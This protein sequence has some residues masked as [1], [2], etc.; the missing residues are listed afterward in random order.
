MKV[1]ILGAH[2][3]ESTNTKLVSLLVDDV[4]ALDAGSL[5]SSLSLE[6]QQRIKAILLTHHHFDHIRDIATFGLNARSWG[7]VQ[8]CG[9]KVTLDA[10]SRYILNGEIYPNLTEK[11][12]EREPSIEF[13]QLE[14]YEVVTIYQYQILPLPV[15]HAIP[16][17][18]YQITS[19][20]GKSLFYSGDTGPGCSSCWEHIAP[21]VIII[22]VTVPN[23]YESE[24]H[25]SG[26]LS[27]HLL[28][29]A[30]AQFRGTKG[31]LP[32]VVLV[33][34]NPQMEEQIREEIDTVAKELGTSITLGHE[35]MTLEL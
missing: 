18:G 14:P 32:P 13:R 17:V 19:R 31:Y 5:T 24:T 11:R 15:Q 16:T 4:L 2:N 35:G 3:L 23:M 34:M 9:T 22:E 8:V 25:D 1:Q 33:H 10:L 12:P 20:E 28:S 26:H 7:T 21:E 29:E 30:L 6:A 27:P